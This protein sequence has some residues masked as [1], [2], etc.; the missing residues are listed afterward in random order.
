MTAQI[1]HGASVRGLR[2]EA[3]LAFFVATA[4]YAE[5]GRPCVLTEGSGGK[6]GR[7]SLHYIGVAID[8]R[9]RDPEGA[10]S[11]ADWQLQ[12]IVDKLRSRLG[13]EYDVV[14]ENDH[15]HVEFQPK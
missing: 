9:I 4:V 13:P 7:A 5:Y 6:H 10:W 2:P 3:L 8:I 1:K 11:L 12:E 15:I 14:L